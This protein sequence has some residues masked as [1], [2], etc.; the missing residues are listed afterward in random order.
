MAKKNITIDQLAVMVKKGF[1]K[2]ASVEMVKDSFENA[3][4]KIDNLKKW[5]EGRFDRIEKLLIEEQNR[6]IEKLESRIEYLENIL[7]LPNR[8]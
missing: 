1:D 3:D 2:T 6:K 8:K 4:G 7:N 5:A